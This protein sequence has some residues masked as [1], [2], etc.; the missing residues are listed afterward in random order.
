ME[1]DVVD[2]FTFVML[3]MVL[4][5]VA[6]A[7]LFR[8]DYKRAKRNREAYPCLAAA[9][10]LGSWYITIWAVFSNAPAALA[11]FLAG[12][13]WEILMPSATTRPK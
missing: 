5:E 10:Y 6:F 8:A 2:H 12:L 9:L 11:G 1:T 7:E 13:A 4:K 3:V